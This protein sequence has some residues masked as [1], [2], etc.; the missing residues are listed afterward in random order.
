MDC[1]GQ[2]SNKQNCKK[3]QFSGSCEWY[4]ANP[5]GSHDR[6]GLVSFDEG[7]E[8]IYWEKLCFIP[9]F[10]EPEPDAEGEQYSIEVL[11]QILTL[12][13]TLDQY[14]LKILAQIIT[15]SDTSVATIAKWRGC[16]RQAVHEKML[17]AA[18]K[19]PFLACI[20]E[21]TNRRMPRQNTKFHWIKLKKDQEIEQDG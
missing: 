18:Y 13:N 15:V 16:S 6:L 8:Q 21:I 2:F 17:L 3:C 4:K 11:L 5:I 10:D 12:L 1:F 20:F 7:V 19:Y 9:Q 14:T